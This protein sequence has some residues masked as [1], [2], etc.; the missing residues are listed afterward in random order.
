MEY[1][2]FEI[3]ISD[4][5]Q[6]SANDFWMCI[7]GVRMPSIQEAEQ[8]LAT[9]IAKH[10]GHVLGVYPIDRKEAE[11]LYDFSREETWPVFGRRGT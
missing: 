11:A 4:K 3:D 6:E 9:D 2:Y 7:R 8:F 1:Q 5:P 10:G